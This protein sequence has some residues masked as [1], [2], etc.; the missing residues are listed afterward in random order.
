MVSRLCNQQQDQ[1]T[2]LT[3]TCSQG[4]FTAWVEREGARL[5]AGAILQGCELSLYEDPDY[6]MV[7]RQGPISC[8]PCF[9]LCIAADQTVCGTCGWRQASVRMQTC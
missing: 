7:F 1:P 9:A 2:S 8:I 6:L 5:A 3:F 4:L